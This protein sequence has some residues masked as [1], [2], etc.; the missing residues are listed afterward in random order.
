M[1][2]FKITLFLLVVRFFCLLAFTKF[3]NAALQFWLEHLLFNI[4]FIILLQKK[5]KTEIR[6]WHSLSY[7]LEVSEMC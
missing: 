2:P 5:K 7:V 4:G 6:L 1:A 3:E